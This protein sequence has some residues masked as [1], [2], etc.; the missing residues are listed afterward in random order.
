MIEGTLEF[1]TN[2]K[3]KLMAKYGDAQGVRKIE[4]TIRPASNARLGYSSSLSFKRTLPDL[5][6]D[7]NNVSYKC[8]HYSSRG[9]GT[10]QS[11]ALPQSSGRGRG[12]YNNNTGR[13]CGNNNSRFINN[14]ASGNQGTQASTP[15]STIPA[16]QRSL[17]NHHVQGFDGSSGGSSNSNISSLM[18]G[19]NIN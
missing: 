10:L 9:R 1:A 8:T 11:Q 17:S 5:N 2:P 13:R 18:V 7:Q 19:R 12:A 3:G 15:F 16:E 6:H 4:K 14:Q